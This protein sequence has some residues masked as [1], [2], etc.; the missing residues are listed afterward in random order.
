M[1]NLAHQ[2]HQQPATAIFDPLLHRYQ[3]VRALSESICAPLQVEDYVIQSMPEISPPKW[4]LAHVS[5]FFETFL[6]KP[7]LDGYR[8]PD[9]RYDY[10]FNSYYETHGTPFPRSQRGL[11][12]RPGV[13]DVYRYRRHVDQAMGELLTNPPAEHAAEIQRRVELGLQHEQQHQELLLMDIKHILAQSPFQPAYRDDLK[14][15]AAGNTERLR[16]HSFG[17]GVKDVGHDGAGFAFDCETPRH[18][19]FIE[20]FQLADRLVTNGEYLS[21]IADGG[22]ARPELWLADGWALLQQSS[23]RS[24]LYWQRQDDAWCEMTLGGLHELRLD[25]PVCHVSFFEAD[26]YSRWAGARLPSEAE[27][28]VA[29]AGQPVRGN[30]LESDHLHPTAASASQEGPAQLYGDVWEWTAS[31]YLPYPGFRPLPGSLGEY[32]GKFMSGQMVLR[33]GCCATPQ[34]HIRATY[35]NFFQPAMRWQFAGLRLAREL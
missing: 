8:T 20:D 11:V 26:A 5:W 2:S 21:F 7:Y 17:G 30:L 32:N 6:L 34:A 14:P 12:S 23:W 1:G 15:A 25:A 31:A 27:W 35:R 4:H 29:A 13:A 18:R 19:Q 9:P 16:W 33:G 22:Y 28:E 24:P 3:Q 10:L